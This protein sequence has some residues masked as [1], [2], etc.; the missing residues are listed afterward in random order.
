MS[1]ALR[2][3]VG[4]SSLAAAVFW[5]GIGADCAVT[6]ARFGRG[7]GAGRHLHLY[8]RASTIR[9]SALLVNDLDTTGYVGESTNM[10][11]D[12]VSRQPQR[13]AVGEAYDA[14]LVES[15]TVPT[16]LARMPRL[17]L[18]WTATRVRVEDL[19]ERLGRRA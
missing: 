8:L 2:C 4:L 13:Y 12:E 18:T 16:A 10:S 5:A 7:S 14:R 9:P 6:V 1:S 17:R 19:L 3:R 15:I 11:E